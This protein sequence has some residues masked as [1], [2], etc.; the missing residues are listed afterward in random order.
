MITRS[1]EINSFMCIEVKEEII[2]IKINSF[3]YIRIISKI[4]KA[5]VNYK[6]LTSK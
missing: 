6:I 5:R 3:Y 1:L 2:N 4:R